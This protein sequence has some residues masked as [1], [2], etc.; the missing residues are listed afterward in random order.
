MNANELADAIQETE[1]YYSTDYKLFDRAA[2]ML[3]QQQ[4]KIEMLEKMNVRLKEVIEKR[5]DIDNALS[6]MK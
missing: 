6:R 2:T 4:A 3:R 1:P 5:I